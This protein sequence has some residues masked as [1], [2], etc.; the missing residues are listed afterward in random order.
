MVKARFLLVPKA[1]NFVLSRRLSVFQSCH[2]TKPN[3][4]DVILA[5][6]KKNKENM[7]ERN[8]GNILLSKKKPQ[9]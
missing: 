7:S 5:N 1:F 4:Y 8:K 6:N 9:P 2:F 3:E